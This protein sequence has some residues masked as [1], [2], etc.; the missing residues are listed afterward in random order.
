MHIV[1]HSSRTLGSAFILSIALSACGGAGSSTTVPGVA[2]ASTTAG[3]SGL[4]VS[5][6]DRAA[7]SSAKVNPGH[8]Y[9]TYKAAQPSR[10]A[11]VYPGDLTFFGGHVVPAAS[12]YNVFVDSTAKTFGY[13]KSFQEHLA[14]SRMIHMADEY[15]NATSDNR[16]TAGG[17][18]TVQYPT[19]TTLGDN[20]L[21]TLIHAAGAGIAGGGYGHIYH[22]YLPPG[23]NYCSTGTLLPLGD[24]NAS[25]TSP[26]PAFC[27]FHGSVVFSDIGETLYTIEPYQDVTYCGVN[28]ATSNPNAPTPNGRQNDSTYST[29]S[30]ETFETITDPDPGTGW[31]TNNVGVH[32]EI[33]DLCAY[34]PEDSS[35]DHKVYRIQREYSNAQH[36]CNNQGP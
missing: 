3:V 10:N 7:I 18:F 35:L 17:D 22:I 27:A 32:G 30:H 11:I 16:Y 15:V 1:R 21:L 9:A 33:G 34:L 8:M 5:T 26:N 13:P 12:S 29:L 2:P 23:V 24:C 31:Y 28:N 36:G 4:R 25:A 19:I 14:A 6:V 20:D